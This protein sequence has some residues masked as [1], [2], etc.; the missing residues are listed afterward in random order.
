MQNEKLLKPHAMLMLLLFLQND[1]NN[2]QNLKKVKI[3]IRYY[4]Q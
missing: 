4:N 1:K 3:K 2:I